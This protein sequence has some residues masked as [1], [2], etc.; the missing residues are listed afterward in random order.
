[1]AKFTAPDH[2]TA[3]ALSSG[4]LTVIDGAVTIV[5][6]LLEGDRAAL[7]SYGFTQAPDEPAPPVKA[8]AAAPVS[9]NQ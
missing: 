7:I 8:K 4:P 9:D 6:E 5:G 2:V 3:I 1:M